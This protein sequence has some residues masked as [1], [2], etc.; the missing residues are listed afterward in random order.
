M[1]KKDRYSHLGDGK[2]EQSDTATDVPATND[3]VDDSAL[4][5]EEPSGQGAVAD[6]S[7]E[8]GGICV[9]VSDGAKEVEFH[10]QDENTTIDDVIE[11]SLSCTSE[12]A[13]SDSP[14]AHGIR[15]SGHLTRSMIG[16]GRIGLNAGA[17][18]VAT[19][20]RHRRR[21]DP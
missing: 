21:D 12:T 6:P 20:L 18:W 5:D 15:A 3:T 14:V 19:F 4:P 7:G 11:A 2:D 1:S 13:T 9:T 17:V 8:T 10:I 16:S